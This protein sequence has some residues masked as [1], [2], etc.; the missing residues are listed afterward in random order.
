MTSPV[1]IRSAEPY[2]AAAFAAIYNPY[3]LG[4]TIS[5]EEEPVTVGAM[6]ERIQKVQGQGLPWLV[7]EQEGE[8]L[9]YAYATRWRERRAYRFAVETS[10]YFSP[11]ARGQGLGSQLYRELIARLQALGAHLA[12]G[13]IALP[14]PA[15]AGL[16]ESLGYQHVATFHEVGWK[17]G[18]WLDVGYWEL[19]LQ[20]GPPQEAACVSTVVVPA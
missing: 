9:G 17:H 7:M 15:S 18:R 4:T 2:D 13:G 14:N 5:F 12:I 6:V 8:I 3:I 16:H 1:T 19:K 11:E 10:V 20:D